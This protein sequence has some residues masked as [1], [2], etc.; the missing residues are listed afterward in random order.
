MA[1]TI[2]IGDRQ[3]TVRAYRWVCKDGAIEAL[4]NAMLDPLGPSGGD[5]NP[6]LHAAQEAVRR[7]GGELISFSP[8][9]YVGG[10][11]Y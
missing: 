10:R 7:F 8:T 1:A 2:R 5:P 3:A 4:L 11:V 9:E 6:D